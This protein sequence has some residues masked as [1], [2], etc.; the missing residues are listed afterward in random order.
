MDPGTPTIG[1]V[2]TTLSPAL[3]EGFVYLRGPR[4]PRRIRTQFK[5]AAAINMC[6]FGVFLF[7]VSTDGKVV[8]I[9]GVGC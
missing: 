9:V 1:T 8:S 5:Q 3:F 7:K 4:L 2:E 6:H